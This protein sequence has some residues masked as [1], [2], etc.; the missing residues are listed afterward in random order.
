MQVAIDPA[1]FVGIESVADAVDHLYS[2][3]SIGKVVVQLGP[4]PPPASVSRL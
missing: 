2:G 3:N 1:R 4:S